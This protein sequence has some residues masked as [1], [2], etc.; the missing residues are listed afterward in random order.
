MLSW[1]FCDMNKMKKK[2]RKKGH[3][4][5]FDGQN[6]ARRELTFTDTGPRPC[7]RVREEPIRSQKFVHVIAGRA[8]G[9]ERRFGEHSGRGDAPADPPHG[10]RRGFIAPD[11]PLLEYVDPFGSKV[12]FYY[13]VHFDH[14]H[15]AVH[16]NVRFDD[17]HFF[18]LP[19]K[20]RV[21][22]NEYI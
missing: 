14:V 10:A 8:I 7:G 13:G 3:H 15:V 11:V 4:G 1:F 9:F 6:K 12:L 19:P 17:G 16:T 5:V 22:K 21:K 2:T 20:M 18:C